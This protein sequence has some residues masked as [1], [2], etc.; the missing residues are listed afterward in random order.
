MFKLNSANYGPGESRG[1]VWVGAGSVF[2]NPFE[3]S[4]DADE[5][6]LQYVSGVHPLLGT[7]ALLG[8]SRH[9]LLASLNRLYGKD[10]ESESESQL[11]TLQKLFCDSTWKVR[12]YWVPNLDRCRSVVPLTSSVYAALSAVSG[13]TDPTSDYGFS[14]PARWPKSTSLVSQIDELLAGGVDFRFVKRSRRQ[15]A[16]NWCSV[17]GVSLLT[18]DVPATAN[19][20][21]NTWMVA[22]LS[23]DGGSHY[24]LVFDSV[25]KSW[26][27]AE[28]YIVHHRFGLVASYDVAEFL[29]V[30]IGE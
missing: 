30:T 4:A 8:L 11:K 24:R 18:K 16:K 3:G 2:S 22:T 17:L 29:P 6:Y 20:E 1:C 13:V 5:Q 25:S 27:S 10:M 12:S 7:N 28:K 14:V 21:F 9:R 19:D 26:I 15:T 23:A